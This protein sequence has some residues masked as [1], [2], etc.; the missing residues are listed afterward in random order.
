MKV[1]FTHAGSLERTE[2]YLAKLKKLDI[3][4][5]AE[6]QAERGVSA[7][8]KNTPRDSGIAANS[9]SYEVIKTNSSVTIA[10]TN[11]NTEGGFPVAIMLQYGHGTGSGGW[12][13]GIDYINPAMRPIFDEIAHTVWKA[14]T[15]A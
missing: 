14:V 2:R 15:S 10:W 9:W 11:T 8:A 5:I 12:V 4:R 1:T 13:Q 6:A 7:L 3:G